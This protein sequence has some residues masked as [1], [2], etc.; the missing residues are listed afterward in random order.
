M[1]CWIRAEK[2]L[3]V[4]SINTVINLPSSNI[5]TIVVVVVIVVVVCQ[6]AIRPKTIPM[7]TTLLPN[8][9]SL[10]V[11]TGTR[12]S[13]LRRTMPQAETTAK[14][15][16]T[17]LNLEHLPSN[18][19]GKR[20]TKILS[21]PPLLPLTPQDLQRFSKLTYPRHEKLSRTDSIHSYPSPASPQH[22]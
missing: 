16:Q 13:L 18:R 2:E 21:E 17:I 7:S 15:K 20:E 1:S 5:I 10:I 11:K 4:L 6:N 3:S 22:P 14:R 9:H 19:K 8:V 12:I